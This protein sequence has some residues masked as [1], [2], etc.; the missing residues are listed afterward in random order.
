MCYATAQ[1]VSCA[2]SVASTV[3]E[4]TMTKRSALAR[5]AVQKAQHASGAMY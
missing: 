2:T 5:L 3:Q 1:T 4:R